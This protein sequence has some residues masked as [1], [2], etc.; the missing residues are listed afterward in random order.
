MAGS[1]M[2]GH[3]V[4]LRLFIRHLSALELI[5]RGEVQDAHDLVVITLG[6]AARGDENHAE[7][8]GHVGL[9]EALGELAGLEVDRL[10][11]HGVDHIVEGGERGPWAR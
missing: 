4:I 6:W 8:A 2:D 9:L 5:A 10:D 7:A 11:T 3:F 1:Q